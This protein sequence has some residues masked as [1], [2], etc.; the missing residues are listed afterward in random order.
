MFLSK[1]I[2]TISVIFKVVVPTILLLNRMFHPLVLLLTI[3]L[4]NIARNFYASNPGVSP[5]PATN[6]FGQKFH[7]TPS[8]PNIV[9]LPPLLAPIRL[10]DEAA[11]L[12]I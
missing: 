10:L 12:M 4:T 9:L 8:L 6:H 3:S 11:I 7:N 1:L 5:K 2:W